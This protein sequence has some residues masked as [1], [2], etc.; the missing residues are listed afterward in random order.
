M[1]G[2]ELY[3]E[4]CRAKGL[5][6]QTQAPDIEFFGDEPGLA[7][8]LLELILCGRKRA[9]CWA[10]LDTEPPA[11][12]SLTVVTGWDGEAGCIIETVRARRMKFS[13]MTWELARLEGE[14]ER[15]E[16]WREGHIRFF[17]EEGKREGYAFS[18]N[19][20][21]IFEEFKVVWPEECVDA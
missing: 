18:E 10:C 2:E 15:F 1:T 5:E 11:S 3:L 6:E 12:G 19:M 7:G 14:D 21:I 16:T 8:R 13:E 9:T 4:Y 20:E 17:T